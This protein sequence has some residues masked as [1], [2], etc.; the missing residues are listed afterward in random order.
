MGKESAL[1]HDP[2]RW[3]KITKENKNNGTNILAEL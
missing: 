1:G 3:M 2:L